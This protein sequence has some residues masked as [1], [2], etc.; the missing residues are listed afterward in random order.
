MLKNPSPFQSVWK[1]VFL[2]LV[3][4]FLVMQ[5]CAI[6]IAS[7]VKVVPVKDV[8]KYGINLDRARSLHKGEG[9]NA[10]VSVFGEP[11]DKQLSCVPDHIVWRYPI[12]AWS[13]MANR[14][15]IVP[16]C[17]LR[18]RF[19]AD[20]ILINWRFIDARTE[21]TLPVM[22]S[23]DNAY[24]WYQSLSLAPA[25]IPPL[26]DLNKTLING[27]STIRQIDQALGRWHPDIYCGGGGPVPIVTKTTSESGSVWDWYVDRPSPLFIPPHYLIVYYDNQGALIGWHFEQTY[28]GGRK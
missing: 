18:T 26:I 16:A 9:E 22:E 4:T 11:A 19:D 3:A 1:T 27:Q 15:E 23:A 24:R 21:H 2:A 14:R 12:R 28:P 10:V 7:G 8:D 13:D 25:P 5:G 20:G 6:T 17:R